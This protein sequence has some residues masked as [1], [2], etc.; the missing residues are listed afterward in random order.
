[1]KM[2]KVILFLLRF[3]GNA[4]LVIQTNLLIFS[5]TLTITDARKEDAGAYSCEAL[6]SK[7]RLFAIPDAILT[8]Y[9][10]GPGPRC[11]CFNHASKCATD[12]SCIVYY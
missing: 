12:G 6:N 2:E 4:K 11:N 3:F 5:G 7:G 9:E 8:V 1:M 10:S